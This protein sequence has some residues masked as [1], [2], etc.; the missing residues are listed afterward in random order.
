M[1]ER[2]HA[3]RNGLP[4]RGHKRVRMFFLHGGD[5]PSFSAVHD[6][7]YSPRP[8]GVDA[9]QKF[10]RTSAV[11]Q[12][13]GRG[14]E[15]TETFKVPEQI[16]AGMPMAD[17]P[18]MRRRKPCGNTCFFRKAMA[19]MKMDLLCP[20]SCRRAEKFCRSIQT[21]APARALHCTTPLYGGMKRS[22]RSTLL[23]A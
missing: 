8:C 15:E 11:S 4:F 3:V 1:S 2:P 19:N 9:G 17:I 7:E 10:G 20:Y 12:K 5:M 16:F 6:Q 21:Y 13:P 14:G 22:D 23:W 18:A